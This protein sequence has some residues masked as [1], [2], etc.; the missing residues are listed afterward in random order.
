MNDEVGNPD[1]RIT[2]YVQEFGVDVEH[3]L[4]KKVHSESF[5]IDIKDSF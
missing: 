1:P 2:A 4:F 3:V 5:N